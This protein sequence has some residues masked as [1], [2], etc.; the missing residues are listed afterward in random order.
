MMGLHSRRAPARLRSSW[1][2]DEQAYGARA[3]SSGRRFRSSLAVPVE[4][5]GAGQCGCWLWRAASPASALDAGQPVIGLCRT[6]G[7]HRSADCRRVSETH[8]DGACFHLVWKIS[9]YATGCLGCGALSIEPEGSP[10]GRRR[11][12][13][14][15][16]PPGLA[17]LVM[18]GLVVARRCRGM[19]VQPGA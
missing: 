9:R 17:V 12:I 5:G 8:S 11:W 10:V 16:T 1:R 4:S 15:L 13:R 3:G 2:S 6:F 18:G 7:S 19:L 14:P